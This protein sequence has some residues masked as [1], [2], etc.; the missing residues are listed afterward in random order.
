MSNKKFPKVAHKGWKQC[1][2]FDDDIMDDLQKRLQKLFPFK[3]SPEKIFKEFEK[4]PEQIQMVLVGKGF[5]MYSIE[6]PYPEVKQK[7]WKILEESEDWD[8]AD[9][10]SAPDLSDLPNCLVLALNRTDSKNVWHEFNERLFMF[11]KKDLDKRLFVC[12]DNVSYEQCKILEGSKNDVIQGFDVSKIRNW[13]KD[14]FDKR[15]YFGLPF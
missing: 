4:P 11:F 6:K 3:P 13:F 7:I 2:A 8:N 5:P 15:I 10:Y 1:N 14:N 12:M 9:E